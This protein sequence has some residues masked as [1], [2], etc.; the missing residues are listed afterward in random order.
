MHEQ[1]TKDCI[2]I[3]EELKPTLKKMAVLYYGSIPYLEEEDII[4]EAYEPIYMAMLQYRK[5]RPETKNR[6]IIRWKAKN[7][8][9]SSYKMSEKTYAMWGVIKYF[10]GKYGKEKM[11]LIRKDGYYDVV[12]YSKFKKNQKYY[13]AIDAEITMY[14]VVQNSTSLSKNGNGDN[15]DHD[16]YECYREGIQ[17][18]IR[19]CLYQE[20]EDV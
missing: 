3:W 17:D 6:K 10:Q 14:D 19:E 9:D 11:V 16:F 8:K 5:N 18:E 4:N 2:R 15:Y 12:S 1:L 20:E 13:E 7:G